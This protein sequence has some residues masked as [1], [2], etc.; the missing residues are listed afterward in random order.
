MI[1]SKSSLQAVSADRYEQQLRLLYARR[2]A[3]DDI[4][5]SLTDYDRCRKQFEVLKQKST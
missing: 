5:R 2:T 4:I 1:V 3:I